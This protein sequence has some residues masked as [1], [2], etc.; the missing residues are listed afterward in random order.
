[1]P[2]RSLRSTARAAG[3]PTLATD[4]KGDDLYDAAKAAFERGNFNTSIELLQ[5]VVAAD[6]KHK[7]AWMDLGR[8]YMVLRQTDNAIDAFKKQAELNP[9]DEYAFSAHRLGLHHR[10]QVRRRRR[11]V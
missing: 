3:T 8:A 11:S 1:M 4:L 10:S 2:I 7:T 5:K 6:P 9:Y